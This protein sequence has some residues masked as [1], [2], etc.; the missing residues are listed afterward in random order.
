[1]HQ[2]LQI[3][4]GEDQVWQIKNLILNTQDSKIAAKYK[5]KNRY[6]SK[7]FKIIK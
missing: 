4:Q 7:E 2:T 3:I 5:N 1:M 6:K